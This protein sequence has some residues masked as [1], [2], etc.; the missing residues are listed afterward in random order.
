MRLSI[1]TLAIVFVCA[2]STQPYI[3]VIHN[4]DDSAK[5][6]DG[7]PAVVYEH[8]GQEKNKFVIF[9]GGGGSCGGQTFNQTIDNCY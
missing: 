1:I 7:S 5:C 9:F 3:K 6:L 8:I 2:L 4:I